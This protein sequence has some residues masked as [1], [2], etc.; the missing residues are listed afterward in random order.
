MQL[1]QTDV[2]THPTRICSLEENRAT[3]NQVMAQG[4]SITLK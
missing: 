3:Y 4:V 2:Y 1:H